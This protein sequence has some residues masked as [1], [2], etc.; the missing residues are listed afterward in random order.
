MIGGKILVVD[1]EPD[2]RTLVKEILE[3]EGFSV[4][5]AADAVQAREMRVSFNPDL[6]LLDIWMPGSTDGIALLKE[7]KEKN[8]IKIPVIMISGHGTVETA[9]EATRIGAYD[10]IE[11][12]ISTAKL[13]LTVKNTLEIVSLQQEN[14]RL[15][16]RSPFVDIPF[17]RS[18][19][20][21]KLHDQMIR[22][23]SHNTPILIIGETGNEKE[24]FARYLHKLG[25]RSGGPFVT[26]TISALSAEDALIALY[27][28][29]EN[30]AMIRKGLIEQAEGGMLFLKDIAD[31]DLTLQA[32][33]QNT[34]ETRSI[35]RPGSTENLPI[36]VR[37][38]AAT[39]RNLGELVPEGKF[40]DDL[41]Y[42]LNVLSLKIPALREHAEDVP[43][44]LEF[45]IK[46]FVETQGLPFR[47]FTP[48]AQS[49]LGNYEWPGNLRELKNLV[50]RLLIM[51]TS[52]TIDMEEIAIALG[53]QPR[54][55]YSREF[56][57]NFD[58]PLRQA[59]EQFE[60][61]YLQ[62]KLEQAD[63]SV[64]KVAVDIGMERTHLYRKLKGLGIE[65]K[66]D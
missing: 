41:Y 43:E 27:G 4:E 22:I 32:R 59:R 18:H 55:T 15:R 6:V 13:V 47:R 12:P 54:Q 65:I 44:L 19:I 7:W 8:L 53:R 49:Y 46:H 58:L 5:T 30:P 16:N 57:A 31:M 52:E 21:Q 26:A 3:D 66:G 9:V 25:N 40:R 56:N 34:I 28:T 29:E 60:K 23:A 37:F 38:V 45:F 39:S 24:M 36:D 63:G 62:Y 20:M 10:F 61:A 48:A 42:Q 17:G 2:I 14:L 64:S 11:K 1:D 33:L 35:S 51:G 50:Q